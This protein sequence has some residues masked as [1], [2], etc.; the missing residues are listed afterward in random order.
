MASVIAC[1]AMIMPALLRQPQLVCRGGRAHNAVR[2]HYV[3]RHKLHFRSSFTVAARIRQHDA[4]T[5]HQISE[6]GA[7]AASIEQ[8][9][10]DRNE[11]DQSVDTKSSNVNVMNLWRRLA[12]AAAAL[13]AIVALVRRHAHLT[14]VVMQYRQVRLIANGVKSSYPS[15]VH[16]RCCA[17]LIVVM[18][19]A[20]R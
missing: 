15:V 1:R 16:V 4:A 20:I 12:D 6:P 2:V 9:S 19:H 8:S 17:C 18:V 7:R 5:P 14:T 13:T 10:L 11:V 3:S